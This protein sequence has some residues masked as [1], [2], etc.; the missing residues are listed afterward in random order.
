MVNTAVR[1][2][3]DPTGETDLSAT[4][5]PKSF[6][7]ADEDV[8]K[9]KELTGVARSSVRRYSKEFLDGFRN[10]TKQ[11]EVWQSELDHAAHDGPLVAAWLG[12]ATILLRLGD[13]WILTDPVFSHR[14]GVKLGPLT[15]GVGRLCPAFDPALLPPLDLIL[16]SHAHFDHLDLPSMK[17]LV[18]ENT[19]V[20]TA[21][22][23]KRLIPK[24]FASVQELEWDK[25]LRVNGLRLRALKPNHWG[26]RTAWDRHRGFNS[27]VL[28]SDK[29]RVLFAGD[30][31]HTEGYSTLGRQGA[32]LTIFGIGAYNPWIQAHACPEQV[33][34]MHQQAGGNFLLPIHHSTFKLSDEPLDEPM[35]RMLQAA[36][37]QQHRVVGREMGQLWTPDHTIQVSPDGTARDV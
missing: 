16:I 3:T 10:N 19:H 30:T 34:D 32:D 36:D 24:G 37:G 22:N 5:A 35:R 20:V 27:Y 17:K 14:I 6:R 28:E 12:H 8:T 29:N 9:L 15:F 11:G 4:P 23:T 26:A 33:W 18:S 31:A 1:D 7:L 21:L 2:L 13:K 25:E